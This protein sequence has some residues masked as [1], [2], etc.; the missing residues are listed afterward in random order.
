MAVDRVLETW[1]DVQYHWTHLRPILIGSEDIRQQLPEQSTSSERLDKSMNEFIA[2]QQQNLS[3]IE[4][5]NQPDIHRFLELQL[6]ELTVIEKSL[7]D[8]LETKQRAFPRF[9]FVSS[10]DLLD[11][12][13]KGRDP[14][15][16]EQHF[17]KVFD[18]LVK[19]EWTGPRTF[20]AMMS[21]ENEKVESEQE[22]EPARAVESWL[23]KLL[24]TACV[25]LKGLHPL[26]GGRI[27]LRYIAA[28]EVDR[29]E[30]RADRTDGRLHPVE[31]GDERRVQ[32]A[33]R[34]H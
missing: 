11:I 13:S 23:Q 1:L 5:C 22:I 17:G 20:R 4:T 24:D 32:A 14:Q 25:T 12:L 10:N 34:G 33:R 29:R 9:Y 31:Q 16:I 18:N 6:K 7:H 28:T 19:V 2:K 21:R 3:V 30:R 27:G 15:D 26:R 8:C